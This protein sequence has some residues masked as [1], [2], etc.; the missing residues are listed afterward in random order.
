MTA[1]GLLSPETEVLIVGAGVLRVRG[2]N[3]SRFGIDGCRNRRS[4][5]YSES[6]CPHKVGVNFGVC[7]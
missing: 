4:I 5:D 2:V 6:A 1:G 7:A 3:R